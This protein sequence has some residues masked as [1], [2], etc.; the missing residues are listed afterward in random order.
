MT[1]DTPQTAVPGDRRQRRDRG[2]R[3]KGAGDRP[4]HGHHA[5]LLTTDAALTPMPRLV[6]AVNELP[7]FHR[8]TKQATCAC[9][10]ANGESGVAVEPGAESGRQFARA[11]A[12][13]CEDSGRGSGRTRK[14]DPYLPRG[15][16]GAASDDD[17]VRAARAVAGSPLVKSALFGSDPNWGRLWMAV[18][19][20]G[21]RADASRLCIRIGDVGTGDRDAETGQAPAAGPMGDPVRITIDLRAR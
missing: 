18:G 21:A 5:G 8:S 13:L 11:L 10:L 2:R 1:T 19:K 12:A 15:C 4:Q 16:L 20:S 17:A 7:D 3:G 6:P 14:G 9:S